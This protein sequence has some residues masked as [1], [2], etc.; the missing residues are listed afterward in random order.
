MAAPGR[1]LVAIGARVEWCCELNTFQGLL[2]HNHCLELDFAYN[3]ST[4]VYKDLDACCIL[5]LGRVK[6]SPGSIAQSGLVTS[7]INVVFDA[8]SCTSK[9]AILRWFVVAS[10]RHHHS[11]IMSSVRGVDYD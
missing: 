7:D 10:R 9:R 11:A 4:S 8:D 6:V 1:H 3:D 5:G 2:S